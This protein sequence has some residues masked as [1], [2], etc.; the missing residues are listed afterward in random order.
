MVGGISGLREK[1]GTT[2]KAVALSVPPLREC[3]AQCLRKLHRESERES[4]EHR[5]GEGGTRAASTGG[6]GGEKSEKREGEGSVVGGEGV[7][8]LGSPATAGSLTVRYREERPGATATRGTRSSPRARL[9]ADAHARTP[10]HTRC[11]AH[12]HRPVR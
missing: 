8:Q 11:I 2:D 10:L 5:R 3:P 9:R 6:G 1:E 7:D 4:E 12:T